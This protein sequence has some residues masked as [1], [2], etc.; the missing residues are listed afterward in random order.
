M[1]N[2]EKKEYQPPRL[3]VVTFK[4]EQGFATSGVASYFMH[5]DEFDQEVG[6]TFG[7]NGYGSATEEGYF[8]TWE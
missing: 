2:Q 4:M 5:L 6:T 1:K 7:R 8:G 3:T